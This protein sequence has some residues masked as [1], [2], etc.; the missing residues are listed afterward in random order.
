MRHCP[1]RLEEAPVSCATISRIGPQ[2]ARPNHVLTSDLEDL[3]A[4]AEY[5]QRVKLERV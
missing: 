5:A 3:E 2:L 1:V 4:L